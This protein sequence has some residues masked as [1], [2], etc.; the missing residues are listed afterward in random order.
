VYLE[1]CLLS[2]KPTGHFRKWMPCI[3]FSC[4]TW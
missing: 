3:F 1:E 2:I 4:D